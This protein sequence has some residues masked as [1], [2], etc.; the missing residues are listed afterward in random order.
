[1]SI[2][3]NA[4]NP[5]PDGLQKQPR[6]DPVGLEYGTYSS[7]HLETSPGELLIEGSEQEED[8]CYVS[9]AKGGSL[10]SVSFDGRSYN[11][12][13][14]PPANRGGGKRGPVKGLSKASR[15]NLLR[16][17]ASIDRDVFK[18]SGGRLFFVTL[19]YAEVRPEDPQ[20]CKEH[21][22]KLHDRLKERFGEFAG[23]WRLG[24]QQQRSAW[25]LHLI[26]YMH[27]SPGLLGDLRS[28]VSVVW[29][30]VCGKVSEGHLRRGTRVVEVRG[31][32][33]ATSHPEKYVARMEAFPEGVTT[34]RVWGKWNASFLPFTP[35]TVGVSFEDAFKVRRIYRRLAG[36]KGTGRLRK[37]QVFVRHETVT[38]LLKF[39][40]D[41][42]EWP[43]GA[44]RPLPPRRPTPHR[45]SGSGSNEE[46]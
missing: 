5:D 40:K 30:E 38:K 39:L 35:E 22:R 19:T 27:S 44:R 8:P 3:S 17:M 16:F 15:R 36:K 9:Y 7:A 25:H 2:N 21:L 43:K 1:M 45:S 23:I 33:R 4:H 32:T 14:T 6:E 12:R 28:F 13:V 20:A 41:D 29:H 42:N 11:G 46:N 18:A 10:S 26:M 37:T 24:F 34:G 31:W